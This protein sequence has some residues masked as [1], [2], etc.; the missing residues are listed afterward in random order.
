MTVVD[1]VLLVVVT[2]V[3]LAVVIDVG[4]VLVLLA[5]GAEVLR[6]VV[7]GLVILAVVVVR[8]FVVLRVVVLML[9]ILA[10]VVVEALVVLFL[11]LVVPVVVTLVGT[12]R[13]IDRVGSRGKTTVSD[14]TDDCI[15]D[16]GI[17]ESDRHGAHGC[18]GGGSSLGIK[19]KLPQKRKYVS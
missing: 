4:V 13:V 5:L 9:V 18:V 1:K 17:D 10:V 15:D 11:M 7:L 19:S 2:L 8:D 12:L 6:V 14:G 3:T 16:G